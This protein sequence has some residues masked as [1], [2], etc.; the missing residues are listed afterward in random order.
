M[1]EWMKALIAMGWPLYCEMYVT[2]PI[3]ERVVP[4][5]VIREDR[6]AYIVQTDTAVSYA[7]LTGKMGNVTNLSALPKVG[8]WVLGVQSSENLFII[9][10]ILPRKNKISRKVSGKRVTEQALATNV[11]LMLVVMGLDNDF[12]LNR[13]ERYL[14]LAKH[15]NVEAVIILNK[16]D[17]CPD[18]DIKYAQVQARSDGQDIFMIS[19]EKG[20]T[21]EDIAERFRPH[22]TGVLI[23]SSGVGK[24]TLT[25]QLVGEAIQETKAVRADD[26]RGMHTTSFR[27]LFLL[28]EGG[29]LIDTPGMRELHLW[30]ESDVSDTA[31][32]DIVDFSAACKFRN[33]AH[34]KEVGC[35]VQQAVASGD[36]DA[37]RLDNYQKMQKEQAYI[38]SKLNEQ[39]KYKYKQSQKKLY[40][41][42]KAYIKNKNK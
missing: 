34:D 14:A 4:A 23:G 24:S 10:E 39:S 33:C 5:R 7:E 12:N 28:S 2:E 19:A 27:Q 38:Q 37:K 21:I 35:A 6:R 15:C 30:D 9:Q 42:Y 26:H 41:G 36:L 18:K 17:I 11:D 31:F 16:M 20:Q 29:C 13:L 1:I 3:P 25:N 8:D 32:Q 22:Q 40:K